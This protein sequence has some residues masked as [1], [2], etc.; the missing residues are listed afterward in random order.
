VIV[1]LSISLL[2]LWAVLAAV[3]VVHRIVTRRR[4]QPRVGRHRPLYVK[5]RAADPRPAPQPAQP[6]APADE[7]IAALRA[8]TET[9]VTP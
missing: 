1:N 6:P 3:L 7:V 5:Q 2:T 4:R 9:E 8:A